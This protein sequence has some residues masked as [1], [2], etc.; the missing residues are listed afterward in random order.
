MTQLL[1]SHKYVAEFIIPTL[2]YGL[3]TDYREIYWYM[4]LIIIKGR[5]WYIVLNCCCILMSS[6]F[7]YLHQHICRYWVPTILLP[8]VVQVVGSHFQK[9]RWSNCLYY[10]RFH[11][12]AQ[13]AKTRKKIHFGR[14]MHCLPQRLKLMFI[15]IFSSGGCSRGPGVKKFFQKTFILVFEVIVA[16]AAT[17]T[18]NIWNLI[19]FFRVLA[20]CAV[21]GRYALL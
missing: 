1:I 17:Q 8:L 16:A 10:W 15:E 4:W 12:I 3:V 13:W 14:T 5:W 6:S 20:H 18:H 7:R 19:F 9:C 21:L 2:F 11:W